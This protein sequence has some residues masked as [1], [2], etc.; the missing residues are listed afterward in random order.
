METYAWRNARRHACVEHFSSK[1]GREVAAK[2][3]YWL[4]FSR[5]RNTRGEHN[6]LRGTWLKANLFLMMAMFFNTSPGQ[7]VQF[8]YNRLRSSQV[9]NVSHYSRNRYLLYPTQEGA[10]CT[11]AGWSFSSTLR[12]ILFLLMENRIHGSIE[13]PVLGISLI[14]YTGIFRTLMETRCQGLTRSGNIL[15]TYTSLGTT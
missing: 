12:P 4:Q 9:F 15:W 10:R 13:S 3:R 14:S 2:D 6:N 7:I 5:P 11:D 1:T 8:H